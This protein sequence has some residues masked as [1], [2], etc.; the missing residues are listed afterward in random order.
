MW[1]LFPKLPSWLPEK[2]GRNVA[3][4]TSSSINSNIS[5]LPIPAAM[6]ARILFRLSEQQ[7]HKHRKRNCNQHR[8]ATRS[9]RRKTMQCKKGN[10]LNAARAEMQSYGQLANQ[11]PTPVTSLWS[12][13]VRLCSAYGTVVLALQWRPVHTRAIQYTTTTPQPFYGP[14]SRTTR[15]SH[16]QKRTS[17]LYGARED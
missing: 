15:V 13:P 7:N 16:W 9:Y 6:L 12:P 3:V 8:L 2:S 5:W 1:A 4:L 11:R 10:Q 14:F 17:G